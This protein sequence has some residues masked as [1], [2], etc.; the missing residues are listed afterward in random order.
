MNNQRPLIFISNDDSYNAP[1]IN[2]LI[3]IARTYGDV[4]VA[5]PE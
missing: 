4:F 2:F 5:A 1:G 3:E